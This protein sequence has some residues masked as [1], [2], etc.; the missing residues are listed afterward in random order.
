MLNLDLEN[1]KPLPA[2]IRGWNSDKLTFRELI[3]DVRPKTII[4]VGT[5]KG[6]SAIAMAQYA[7]ATGIPCEIFCVDTWLGSLEFWRPDEGQDDNRDLVRIHGYP[8]VYYQFLSNI[9]HAGVVDMIRPIPATAYIGSFIVPEA[10]LIY[11]DGSHLYEDVKADI[12]AYWPK[13]K[14]GGV[15]FGDDYHAF[16]GV[17]KA[18]QE[19][20]ISRGLQWEV[21]EDNFW[22]IKKP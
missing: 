20:V 19:F 15:M 22:I 6:A 14:S 2:D 8:Q 16:D 13:L 18:V 9:V 1:F 7:R 11:I 3:A 17:Q 21:R 10:E 4:E 5:W 12:L